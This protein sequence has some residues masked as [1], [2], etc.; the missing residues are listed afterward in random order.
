M[1]PRTEVGR[2]GIAQQQLIEIARALSSDSRLL[3]MDEPTATLTPREIERLFAIIHRLRA[4][5]VTVVYISHRLQEIYEIADRVTV[6]RN[7]E[8]VETARMADVAIPELVRMMVGKSID[9][10]QLFRD[11]VSVGDTILEVE[12]LGVKAT[13]RDISFSLRQSE[14]LGIAGLV[15]SGRTETVRAL[16]GA[17]TKTH[18]RIML[19]GQEIQ[20]NSP[21]DAVAHGLCLLTEDRKEQGLV[22]DMSCAVNITLADL[23]KF[24]SLG[25]MQYDKEARAATDLVSRLAIRTPSIRQLVKNLSGGNQQKIVIAKWLLRERGYFHFRRADARH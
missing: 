17:D 2:L 15:G 24:A 20:I 16:F 18:G 3:I 9:H 23:L 5:G 6:L 25:L 14:I 19:R 7:G 1:S 11:D 4:N 21:R 12:G 8:R 10:N 13:G 22:L